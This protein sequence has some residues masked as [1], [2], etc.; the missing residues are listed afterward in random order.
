MKSILVIGGVRPIHRLLKNANVKLILMIET[1]KIKETDSQEYDSIIGLPLENMQNW[2]EVSDNLNKIE[3]FDFIACFDESYQN[4]A[5]RIAENINLDYFSCDTIL[6]CSNK[7]LMRKKINTLNLGN[8]ESKVV[9]SEKEIKEFGDRFGYPLILKPVDG[10]ASIGV[11]KI[12]S[13]SD[14]E[15]C[16]RWFNES[17]NKKE[18]YIEEFI[19]GEEISVESFSEK[20]VH[21][22]IC[23]TKKFKDEIHFIEQGHVLPYKLNS[24]I[25]KEITE[26]VDATLTVLGII[27]GPSHCEIKITER[28]PKVIEVN[29]RLGGDYIN[30]LIKHTTECDLMDLWAK[31]T[32]GESI[33]NLIPDKN[34]YNSYSAIWFKTSEI[35][36][37]LKDTLFI[38]EAEELKGIQRIGNL[39]VKGGILKKTV[40]S[41]SRTTFAIAKGNSLDDALE[42]AKNACEKVKLLIEY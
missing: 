20:G 24:Q 25:E 14:I 15:D 39:Q 11:S 17:T 1:N 4:I 18:M 16:I 13:A 38:E 19:D 2:V 8:V 21:K 26:L 35:T 22:I 3:K 30:E 32:L 41:Y 42:N 27:N 28:G 5:A 9:N 12:N 34:N 29:P 31:Q 40:D 33:F 37:T 36:A 7:F 23:F 10:M 6:N